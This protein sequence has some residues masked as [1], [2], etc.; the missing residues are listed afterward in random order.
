MRPINLKMW[1][2]GS[3]DFYHALKGDSNIRCS[4]AKFT[5]LAIQSERIVDIIHGLIMET[6]WRNYLARQGA[7]QAPDGTMTLEVSSTQNSAPG[8]DSARLYSCPHLAVARCSGAQSSDFLQNQLTCDLQEID[9]DQWTMGAYCTPKGRV[10][11][12]LRI[13]PDGA[14]YLLIG[15]ISLLTKLLDR[16]RIYVMR[17]D[18]TFTFENDTTVL[19]LSGMGFDSPIGPIQALSNFP[20]RSLYELKPCYFL[21]ERGDPAY[22]L[23]LAPTDTAIRLWEDTSSDV[24]RCDADQWILL[25]IRAGN[26]RVTDKTSERFIPQT[27]N[28]DLINAV[29]FNKGCYP[30]QEIVAR[31]RYRSRPKHR[32]IRVGVSHRVAAQVGDPVFL[33]NKE[34][35]VGEV[36]AHAHTMD[37]TQGEML[38]SMAVAALDAPHYHLGNETSQLTRLSLPYDLTDAEPTKTG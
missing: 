27:L 24:M 3:I 11:S 5:P 36:V 6:N 13:V 18:V 26:P 35:R 28:L 9:K 1:R 14:D 37:H 23:I 16:L 31:V 21:R 32:M 7:V 22:G 8:D 33:P 4:I 12:I 20:E 17:T 38:I 19:G 30:G 34:Q 25:E 15:E 2:S 10:L 29:S